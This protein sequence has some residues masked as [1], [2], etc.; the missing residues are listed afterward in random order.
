[1]EQINYF[2]TPERK[3]KFKHYCQLKGVSM[4]SMLNSLTAKE[5]DQNYD[6]AV[7]LAARKK[8]HRRAKAYRYI[9]GN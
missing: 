6:R 2:I 5:L 8:M 3:S 1:M 4:T 9:L 7:L